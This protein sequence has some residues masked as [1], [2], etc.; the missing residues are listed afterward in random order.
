MTTDL[1]PW[2]Q[3]AVLPLVTRVVGTRRVVIGLTGDHGEV[4]DEARAM[5]ES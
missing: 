4:A 3:N 5:M 2:A 1:G